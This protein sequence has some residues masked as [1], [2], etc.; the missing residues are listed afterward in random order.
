MPAPDRQGVDWA[1]KSYLTCS[2]VAR[3]KEHAMQFIKTAPALALSLV[4][5]ACGGGDGGGGDT[6]TLRVDGQSLAAPSFSPDG[7]TMAVVA[8]AS[9][10]DDREMIA[11]VGR[12]GSGFEVLALADSYLAGTTFTPDGNAVVYTGDGGVYQVP[13]AGGTPE[14]LVDA[15]AATAPD[16]S[17][18]G[19]QL[20][21]SVNGGSVQI[22]DFAP[23][24]SAT[25]IGTSSAMSPSFSPDGMQ[26]AYFSGDN[27]HVM[28]V[29]G[30]NDTIVLEA[31]NDFLGS[32]DWLD[33][34]TL[35][36]VGADSIDTLDIASG[37]RTPLKSEFVALDLA[38][39]DDGSAIAYGSNP[40]S[41]ITVLTVAGE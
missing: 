23:G 40:A 3:E 29:T 21:Y 15:F 25:P 20:I 27:I 28:D 7:T 38:S 8:R 24:A 1:S 33:N 12:D 16:V 18:D 2:R 32:V 5:F 13:V 17:P 4:L 41:A 37:T 34:D 14:L 22:A 9:A 36:F 39:A 19:S 11:V 31:A 30:D 35:V 10:G 26:I 6:Q